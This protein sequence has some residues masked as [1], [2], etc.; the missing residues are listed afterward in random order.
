[1]Y[2]KLVIVRVLVCCK[3]W[4]EGLGLDVPRLEALHVQEQT[5]PI[6]SFSHCLALMNA[7]AQD[8]ATAVCFQSMKMY[9]CSVLHH[10]TFQV[11]ATQE[12]HGCV[13]EQKSHDPDN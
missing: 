7:V 5:S 11:L 1:M 12:H 3:H 13:T 2:F 9:K 10:T 8:T 4:T 6:T